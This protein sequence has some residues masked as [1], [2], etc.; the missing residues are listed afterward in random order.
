MKQKQDRYLIKQNKTLTKKFVIKYA[1]QSKVSIINEIQSDVLLFKNEIADYIKSNSYYLFNEKGIKILKSQYKL[2]SKSKNAKYLIGSEY[3][4]IFNDCCVLAENIFQQ[5]INNCKI[6]Q[7]KDYKINK[8]LKNGN[9]YKKG[10]FKEVSFSKDRSSVLVKMINYLIYLDDDIVNSEVTLLEQ[11]NEEIGAIFNLYMTTKPA[12]FQRLVNFSRRLRIKAINR[13]NNFSFKTGSHRKSVSPNGTSIANQIIYDKSNKKYK[14]W[15]QYYYRNPATNKGTKIFLPLLINK[16]YHNDIQQIIKNNKSFNIILKGNKIIID[17][18]FNPE[19]K[20][21]KDFKK[22]NKIMAMDLNFKHNILS[23]NLDETYD[24]DRVYVME[25]FLKPLL[26]LSEKGT[27]NF[28]D[29]EAMLYTKCFRRAEW[30][31]T[32]FIS[33]VLSYE[34]ERG[35]TDIILEDLSLSGKSFATVETLGGLK[36]SRLARLLRFTEFKRIFKK[37]ANKKGIRVHFTY[38]AYTSQQCPK[39]NHIHRD[40]RLEQESFI[41]VNCGHTDDAD[42]NSPKNMINRLNFVEDIFL[43]KKKYPSMTFN[44]IRDMLVKKDKN[45]SYP[46]LR[47]HD[48]DELGQCFPNHKIKFNNIKPYLMN[49]ST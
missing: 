20:T 38:S 24:F 27:Q 44:Q 37:L 21:E 6:Y 25:S 14:Y 39:C 5:H 41:C 30:L 26:A 29:K 47:F 10:D 42:F 4:N 46:L 19:L 48:F 1:N 12:L 11:S 2:F 18:T 7:I 34:I 40:N 8:Y 28:T 17:A 13:F 9:G 3:Q 45:V 49:G 43:L 22:F 35:T 23:T 36:I 33:D 15:L 16:Q 32:H 31:I